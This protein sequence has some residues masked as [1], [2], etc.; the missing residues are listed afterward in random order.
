MSSLYGEGSIFDLGST[1]GDTASGATE[2]LGG[3]G[4]NPLVVASLI[5]SGFNLLG[6]FFGKKK[7]QTQTQTQT[8]HTEPTENYKF[9]RD[10]FMKKYGVPTSG[11]D[12]G[13]LGRL[14]ES[15]TT[16][17]SILDNNQGGTP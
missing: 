13:F 5:S 8:Q 3:A 9:L 2:A 11:G 4:M 12:G 6:N 17:L 7:K 14:V 16:G 1:T 15:G 10:Y